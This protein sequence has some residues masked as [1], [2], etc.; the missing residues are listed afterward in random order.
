MKYVL[1]AVLRAT[2][3]L[4]QANEADMESLCAARPDVGVCAELEQAFAGAPDCR[5][6]REGGA[7]AAQFPV[8]D[9]KRSSM[10]CKFKLTH[11][12]G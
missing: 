2:F 12:P 10:A 9:K 3:S 5:W 4:A 7:T 1:C 8:R 6:R 11:P